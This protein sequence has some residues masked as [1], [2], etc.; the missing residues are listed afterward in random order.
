V[1]EASIQNQLKNVASLDYHEFLSSTQ[2]Q[3][4]I[5]YKLMQ[6]PIVNQYRPQD[7][8]LIEDAI[9]NLEA[10]IPQ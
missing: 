5:E 4:Q 9:L 6:K 7:F 3:N 8:K 2:K 10:N 1:A